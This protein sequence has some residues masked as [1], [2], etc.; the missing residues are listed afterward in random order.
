MPKACSASGQAKLRNIRMKAEEQKTRKKS[1]PRSSRLSAVMSVLTLAAVLGLLLIAIGQKGGSLR[2]SA[3][4]TVPS[5]PKVAPAEPP[6]VTASASTIRIANWNLRDCALYNAKTKEREPLHR[7]VAKALHDS[8]VD[9]AVFEEIQG[10]G[11]KGGDIALLSV[12]LAKEGWAMPYVAL[13]SSKSEDDIAVFSRYKILE[14]AQV[15]V[16]ETADP[17]P[18]PGIYAR[19][20]AG[21]PGSQD[22]DVY[23]FHFKAMDDAKSYGARLA[24]AKALAN[25]LLSRYGTELEK[26]PIILAGDFNTVSPADFAEKNSVLSFL[27][28]KEDSDSA[29][30]FLPVNYRFF[31]A[32]PTFV[33]RNYQSLL[34]H[35]LISAS[36]AQGFSEKKAS[37]V[38]PPST[39]TGIPVS[40]HRMIIA[41]IMI[42][43]QH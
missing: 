4:E 6:A 5:P 23:G 3:Q 40:D 18:R 31:P 43:I 42:P 1:Q 35:L 38:L 21:S 26:K 20:S 25:L 13:S 7:Y 12:A 24:Q 15:L 33:D 11:K 37:I 19:V 41:D 17:W 29:N 16:P 34:D 9:I 10:D 28:L 30:D 27:C 36:L 39:E 22:L 2:I 14:S 8:R 32:E